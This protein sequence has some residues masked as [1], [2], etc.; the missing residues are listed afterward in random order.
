ML[1][2]YFYINELNDTQK[3]NLNQLKNINIIYRNYKKENYEKNAAILSR[4]CK[5]K[6]FKFY[7]SNDEKLAVRLNCNGIYLPSFNTKKYFSNTRFNIIGSAHNE[8]EIRKKISQGCKEIFL[9]PIFDTFSEYS[10]RGIGLGFYRKIKS[11]FYNKAK[12]HALG[13]INEKNINKII[14]SN[15]PGFSS[16]SFIEKQLNKKLISFLKLI[17]TDN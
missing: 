10:K 11:S 8:V 9:S 2:I 12:I 3:E 16:I 1:K 15:S 5:K 17:A 4:Y 7:I 6:R 13:G 14:V